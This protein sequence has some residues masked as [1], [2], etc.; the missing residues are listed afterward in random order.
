[1][2]TSIKEKV[3]DECC[4]TVKLNTHDFTPKPGITTELAVE[5]AGMLKDLGVDKKY[6]IG[7]LDIPWNLN[8]TL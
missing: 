3:P 2:I 7:I 8:L 5:Y 4:I 1:M 6:L